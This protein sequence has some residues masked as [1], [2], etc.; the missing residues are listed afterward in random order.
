MNRFF[1]SRVAVTR[2]ELSLKQEKIFKMNMRLAWALTR[3]KIAQK[4][5]KKVVLNV[6]FAVN[7]I[8]RQAISA[9]NVTKTSD[10]HDDQLL[11]PLPSRGSRQ[12]FIQATSPCEV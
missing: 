5:T 3:S 9:N 8:V 11:M 7:A 10:W 2:I 1:Q 6:N 12:L 4:S